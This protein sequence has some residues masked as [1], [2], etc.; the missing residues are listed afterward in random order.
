MKLRS[1]AKVN[2]FL[3]V[4]H[5]REEGYHEIETLF[6]RISLVD[7]IVLKPAEQGIHVRCVWV[8]ADPCVGPNAPMVGRHMGRPLPQGRANLAYQAAKILQD[9]FKIKQGIE[10]TI[11]KRIPMAAGLGGG[12]SNAA[13]VLLGLNRFWNLK[14]PKKKLMELMRTL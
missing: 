14:C 7:E 13:T 10:I 9:E 5:K 2:L 8:G 1:P 12:S 11:R 3:N 4:L 6:E